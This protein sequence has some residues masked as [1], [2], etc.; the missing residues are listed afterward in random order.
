MLNINNKFTTLSWYM[1]LEAM[2]RTGSPSLLTRRSRSPC[3]C[4]GFD[5]SRSRKILIALILVSVI[6]SLAT[7]S[8][9]CK[10]LAYQP[11]SL[12]S[13]IHSVRHLSLASL[14]PA[15]NSWRR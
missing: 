5:M 1:A 14:L 6:W 3:S 4:S 15:D 7:S 13:N 11:L 9:C 8:S 12:C 2:L 10:N